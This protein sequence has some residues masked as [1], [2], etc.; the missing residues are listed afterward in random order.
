MHG[1]TSTWVLKPLF[2]FVVYKLPRCDLNVITACSFL[3]NKF[4][5]GCQWP[6][7]HT[8]GSDILTANV[9][10]NIGSSLNCFRRMWLGPLG[11]KRPN[12]FCLEHPANGQNSFNRGATFLPRRVPHAP[13]GEAEYNVSTSHAS[14]VSQCP[15]GSCGIHSLPMPWWTFNGDVVE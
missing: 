11:W 1:K 2:H 14:A 15:F 3:K 5:S 4:W 8:W 13:H 12:Q 6:N 7:K 9:I 10:T